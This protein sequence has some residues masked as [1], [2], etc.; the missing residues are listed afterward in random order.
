MDNYLFS[1]SSLR[2]TKNSIYSLAMNELG[3][4]IIAGS[5][6]NILRVWD[7][8]TCQ[9]II[10]LRGHSENIRA[11]S[12]NREGTLVCF[13]NLTNCFKKIFKVSIRK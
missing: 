11:I 5:T 13:F 6:E 1:A 3:T 9:K 8:R 7:P 4:V 2:G 10:K 12:V